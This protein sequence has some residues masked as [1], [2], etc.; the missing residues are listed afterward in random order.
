MVQIWQRTQ[1]NNGIVVVGTI[2][3]E[4]LDG[5]DERIYHFFL[6]L[7]LIPLAIFRKQIVECLLWRTKKHLSSFL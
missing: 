2:S 7:D 6:F 3:L 1:T 5:L 4:L